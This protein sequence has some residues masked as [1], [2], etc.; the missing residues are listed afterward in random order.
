MPAD[1]QEIDL[2]AYGRGRQAFAS[3][4]ALLDIAKKI[5][6]LASSAE[7]G[8]SYALG[9]FDAAFDQLR[10]IGDRP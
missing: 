7:P 5:V 9:F 2:E 6:S 4:V 10:G 1:K 3:G 8:L